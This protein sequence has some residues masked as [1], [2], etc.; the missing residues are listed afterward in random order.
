MFSTLGSDQVRKR[1]SQFWTWPPLQ[2]AAVHGSTPERPGNLLGDNQLAPVECCK[3]EEAETSKPRSLKLSPTQAV[4]SRRKAIP[5]ILKPAKGNPVTRVVGAIVGPTAAKL[6]TGWHKTDQSF[7]NKG[8]LRH[9]QNV[10]NPPPYLLK[11]NMV[12]HLGE[13]ADLELHP[14]TS[15]GYAVRVLARRVRGTAQE[16]ANQS[17]VLNTKSS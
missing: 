10:T 3:F 6:A 2:R 8:V 17:Y 15:T 9:P 7:S 12:P 13:T 11:E 5:L 16:P 14:L 1:T 4:C